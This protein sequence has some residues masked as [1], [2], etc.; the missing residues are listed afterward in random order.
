MTIVIQCFQR[1]Q[2]TIRCVD[3]KRDEFVHRRP[4]IASLLGVSKDWHSQWY[5]LQRWDQRTTITTGKLEV[6]HLFT[7]LQFTGGCFF[8]YLLQEHLCTTMDGG[9]SHGM[10]ETK[11]R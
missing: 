6:Q 7:I 10:I 9:V 11:G 8:F 1:K 5:L 2:Q 3:D 4:A